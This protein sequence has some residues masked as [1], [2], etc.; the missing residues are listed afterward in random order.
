VIR[1]LLDTG[2][3][4]DY[5]H[6]R[7]NVFERARSEVAK[8]NILGIGLP[9]LAELVAGIE[10]SQTRDRNM[11]RLRVALPQLK[12]WP[13]DAPAAYEYGRIYAELMSIGRPIGAMDMMIG[14]IALTLGNCRVVS[15]D[16]DLDDIPNLTTENWRIPGD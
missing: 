16:G 14:A 5:I 1:F 3:A 15:C 6:R 9:V 10:R 2:I 4:S 13:F 7:H 11:Q 8:G 12:L